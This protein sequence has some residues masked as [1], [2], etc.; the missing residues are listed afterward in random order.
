MCFIQIQ[1]QHSFFK[2]RHNQ[3]NDY[4]TTNYGISFYTAKINFLTPI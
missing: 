2:T 4:L 3:E 1:G